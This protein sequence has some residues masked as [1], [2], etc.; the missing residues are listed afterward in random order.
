ML[1]SRALCS[2]PFRNASTLLHMPA[3]HVRLSR[4]IVLS[5]CVFFKRVDMLSVV[6]A[7]KAQGFV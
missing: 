2:T 6:L 4:D 3:E 7:V 5:V 1:C